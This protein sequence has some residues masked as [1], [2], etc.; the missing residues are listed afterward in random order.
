MTRRVAIVLLTAVRWAPPGASVPAWRA[1]LA[2]DMVDMV[3]A[4]TNVDPAVAFA[5]AD[6]A[7]AAALTW[8]G[9]RVYELAA[10]DPIAALAAATADGYH[11]AA[12]LPAD[13]PDL[14]GLLVAKLF[15]ALTSRPVAVAAEI[16]GPGLLGLAARLPAPDWLPDLD[17]DAAGPVAIRSAAPD[18]VAQTPGWHRL[19]GPDQLSHLD[20]GL[21]GWP[22]T[23]ALITA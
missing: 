2:E 17:L 15:R 3:S 22:A 19:R 6:R 1:A 4:L 7:L 18:L 5:P 9:T 20:P 10:A 23:R 12:L 8:P 14:P 16:G 21:E 13:A 11:H